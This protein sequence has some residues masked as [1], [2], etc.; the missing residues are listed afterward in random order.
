MKFHLNRI[1]VLIILFIAGGANATS[2]PFCNND[3][4][5]QIKDRFTIN[6]DGT[7]KDKYTNLIWQR[8]TFGEEWN[9]T[10]QRCTGTPIGDNW[11]NILV[12]IETYNLNQFNAGKTYDWRLPNIKEMSSLATLE[13]FLYAID[14]TAFPS[15]RSVYWTSTPFAN[16]VAP[17]PI[18]DAN[19]NLTGFQDQN[20]IWVV[21]VKSGKENW[22]NWSLTNYY[23][24]LVRGESKPE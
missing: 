12:Q 5:I 10:L 18:Y 15:P 24:L 13:C 3:S 8:C 6:D 17:I 14:T 4:T 20:M 23:A 16:A 1:F 21:D 9:N 22:R 2:L 11:R 7:V 19:D